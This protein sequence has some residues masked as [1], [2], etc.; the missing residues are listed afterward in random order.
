[1]QSGVSRTFQKYFISK[2]QDINFTSLKLIGYSGHL[3]KNETKFEMKTNFLKKTQR[4]QYN[5][6]NSG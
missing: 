6:L 2:K 4:C 5:A 1:M 3:F